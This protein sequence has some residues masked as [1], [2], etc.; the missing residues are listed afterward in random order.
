MPKPSPAKKKKTSTKEQEKVEVDTES[1]DD[2][3]YVDEEE[4]E[5]D[6][7][8]EEGNELTDEK[9]TA[10][11]RQIRINSRRASRQKGYRNW[12]KEAGTEVGRGQ[13]FA[14]DMLKSVYSLPDTVRAA[15]WSSHCVDP[16]MELRDMKSM[17]EMREEA[18][19]AGA[20]RVLHANMESLARNVV[21]E[22][23]L[24]AVEGGVGTITASNIRSVVRPANS[25]LRLDSCTPLG[26]V[27]VAQHVK[28]TKAVKVD[29]DGH[30]GEPK[31]KVV[32]L[33]HTVLKKAEDDDDL[34]AAERAFAK[35]NHVKLLKEADKERNA[36]RMAKAK[37]RKDA[38]EAKAAASATTVEV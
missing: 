7:E 35:Q 34:I 23:V 38:E 9:K 18:I 22:V 3:K 4:E 5:E 2:L 25:A 10:R 14:N 19:P 6:V 12:A 31:T 30:P 16:G 36:K 17:L 8:E 27:R 15:K 26:L 24:R 28:R 37:K 29:E 11:I 33:D 13:T 21:N 32:E 1:D 20:A